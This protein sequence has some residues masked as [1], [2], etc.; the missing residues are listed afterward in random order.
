MAITNKTTILVTK[1]LTVIFR[2]LT[3]STT[4]PMI[5]GGTTLQIATKTKANTPIE[6]WR[7]CRLKNQLKREKIPICSSPPIIPNLL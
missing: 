2:L 7:H 4:L 3:V 1:Y 5:R 6:Y